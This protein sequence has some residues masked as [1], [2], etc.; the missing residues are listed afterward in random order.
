MSKYCQLW[1]T[2]GNKEEAD[3]IG[4]TLLDKHL[5]ACVRQLPISSDYWW[6]NKIEHSEEIL[7]QMESRTDLFDKVEGEVAKQHSYETFVLEAVPIEKIS[8]KAA[9]WLEDE[10][11]ARE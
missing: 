4:Q 3:K 7:L 8:K 10:S 9:G 11:Y 6:K 1:L 5:V 2:V